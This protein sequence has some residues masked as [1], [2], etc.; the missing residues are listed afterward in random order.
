MAKYQ[1]GESGNRNGAPPR[2]RAWA[3]LIRKYGVKKVTLYDGTELP[4]QDI[5][6]QL[7]IQALI[8]GEIVFPRMQGDP[9]KRKRLLMR[10]DDWIRF[11]GKTREHMDGKIVDVTSGGEQLGDNSV[12]VYLPDNKREDK[13]E[14]GD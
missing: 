11:L 12:I 3:A 7:T 1:K 14:T 2:E 10:A 4:A 8:T 5:I 13:D 6:A 9:A